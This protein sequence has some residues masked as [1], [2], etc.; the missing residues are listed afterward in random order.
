MFRQICF[1]IAALFL[2]QPSELKAGEVHITTSSSWSGSMNISDHVIVDSN[3]VLTVQPGTELVFQTGVNHQIGSMDLGSLTVHGRLRAIG[4]KNL[5]ITFRG[6]NSNGNWGI[7]FLDNADSSQL[8]FC[9]ISNAGYIENST[10][11]FFREGAVTV[12]STV[13]KIEN[14]RIE[15]NLRNGLE[16]IDSEFKISSS[17]LAYNGT[18]G[19]FVSGVNSETYQ[20]NQKISNCI[21]AGNMTGLKVYNYPSSQYCDLVNSIIDLGESSCSITGGSAGQLK[22][23]NCLIQNEIPEGVQNYNSQVFSSSNPLFK[24]KYLDV[25]SFKTHP[26]SPAIDRGD[27]FSDDSLSQDLSGFPRIANGMIDVGC[28]EFQ[29]RP[30]LK[31]VTGDVYMNSLWNADTVLVIPQYGNALNV[32]SRLDI[33]KGTKV[34]F[35][36]QKGLRINSTGRIRAMGEKNFTVTFSLSDTTGFFNQDSVGWFGIEVNSMGYDTTSFRYAIF[37]YVKP[38]DE[39]VNGGALRINNASVNITASLFRYNH[40]K[41]QGGAIYAYNC[42][43]QILSSVFHHNSSNSYG[44]AIYFDKGSPLIGNSLFHHNRAMIG[45]A[46]AFVSFPSK[47]IAPQIINCSVV[48]N[49]GV[50]ICGGIK[51]EDIG[52]GTKNDRAQIINSIIYGN[53]S[54]DGSQIWLAND[55]IDPDISYSLIENGINGI[56]VDG[57]YT[58]NYQFNLSANP[59]FTNTMSSDYTLKANSPCI[60]RGDASVLPANIQDLA[61]NPRIFGLNVD[62]GCFES[63]E[64]P[65]RPVFVPKGGVY[66]QPINVYIENRNNSA[67]SPVIRYTMN[68]NDVTQ[69]SPVYN[70]QPL[71]LASGTTMIKA[72]I[73]FT[74]QSVI[75]SSDVVEALYTIGGMNGNVH[76]VLKKIYSPY[77]VN[78]MLTIAQ[79]DSLFIEPG[80]E[81]IATSTNAGLTVKGKLITLGQRNEPVVF[82]AQFANTGW[83]GID[84]THN[85]SFS[86][87]NFTTIKDGRALLGTD[88]V[89]G[90]MFLNH[91]KV[92]MT[93]CLINGNSAR[94]GG[95]ISLDSA[96]ILIADSCLIAENRVRN[97]GGGIYTRNS[98]LHLRRSR[99]AA[100]GQFLESALNISGSGSGI[101]AV[102][103]QLNILQN[104]IMFNDCNGWGGGIYVS[105]SVDSATI[106]TNNNI[107]NN[108]ADEGGGGLKLAFMVPPGSYNLDNNSFNRNSAVKN[109]IQPQAGGAISVNSASTLYLRNLIAWD[110]RGTS[111]IHDPNNKLSITYSDIA[112]AVSVYPGIGNINQAPLFIK[113]PDIYGVPA[114][115]NIDGI[116]SGFYNYHLHPTSP[117][118]NSGDPAQLPNLEPGVN[119]RVNMGSYGNTRQ[120]DLT[121]RY[122][123]LPPNGYVFCQTDSCYV[124]NSNQKATLN[125]LYIQPGSRVYLNNTA[126]LAINDLIIESDGSDNS[127]CLNNFTTERE[128]KTIK[129]NLYLNMDNTDIQNLS[130]D[131]AEGS[132]IVISNVRFNS[133]GSGSEAALKSMNSPHV[134]VENSVINSFSTGLKIDATSQQPAAL[135]E[136]K[137]LEINGGT[138]LLKKGVREKTVG[139]YANTSGSFSMHNSKISDMDTAAVILNSSNA[140]ITANQFNIE[141]EF[142]DGIGLKLYGVTL[143]TVDSNRV[144][145]GIGGFDLKGSSGRLVNNSVGF[146]G[147]LSKSLTSGF[148]IKAENCTDLEIVNNTL[149]DSSFS[150]SNI[151]IDL[152]GSS[153]RLVNNSVGFAGALSKGMKKGIQLTDCSVDSLYHNSVANALPGLTIAGNSDSVFVINNIFWQRNDL[154]PGQLNIDAN[155]V[156]YNNNISG[157]TAYNFTPHQNNVNS[158]PGFA[159]DSTVIDLQLTDSSSL[160]VNGGRLING[161]HVKNENYYGSAPDMGAFE[162][163]FGASASGIEQN[164]KDLSWNL[165]QNYPNPFNPLTTIRYTVPFGY[166]GIVKLKIYNLQGQIVAEP[167][168]NYHTAGIYQLSYNAGRLSSGVYF[169]QL[170]GTGF[171]KTRRMVVLK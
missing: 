80:V 90:A 140:R 51:M 77:L 160:C 38:Y 43:P 113:L 2:L 111:E 36:N 117:C 75:D 126:D 154:S 163:A 127:S 161:Y 49:I 76:G 158:N 150:G 33:A 118:I 155:T 61:G 28:Y 4:Q 9:N 46:M 100:N 134:V 129:V 103:S 170:Q 41:N 96:S 141:S 106:I 102:N 93:K 88:T 3:V 48:D 32:N 165:L 69:S 50:E 94:N 169:Y 68:G 138:Q 37:E 31:I 82:K 56:S 14:C 39:Y 92:V 131:C 79:G 97:H 57:T 122:V 29:G 110:N 21:I 167:L 78:S 22:F 26:S 145:N 54:P 85:S 63:Q 70:N 59:K 24:P 133:D 72:R 114:N 151:G 25:V 95:G 47:S 166:Q 62:M 157:I 7:I 115:G 130:F 66:A 13:A 71:L 135:V 120:A 119:N 11:G 168:N 107:C 74:A 52:S 60:D 8:K 156:L 159:M 171:I 67:S 142:S 10:S 105:Q 64:Q 144:D 123:Q 65:L 30:Q 121:P 153:G 44:G 45:G 112:S 17:L 108:S 83:R 132:D 109:L 146:A 143:F 73:Y 125:Q 152:K 19:I 137:N 101:Y 40:S 128:T 42:S 16:I 12:D 98:A 84:F 1:W 147:A 104:N 55:E 81:I 15:H 86:K 27:A 18:N 162:S 139:I 136:L 53:T 20:P 148:G 164:L 89:G 6:S 149:T 34:L 91:G 58:G 5:P 124:L 116:N 35:G 99:V 23:Q 87:L